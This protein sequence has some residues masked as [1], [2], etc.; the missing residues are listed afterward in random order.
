MKKKITNTKTKTYIFNDG[1]FLSTSKRE[2]IK[3][4]L[5]ISKLKREI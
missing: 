1:L 5:K 4:T 3:E 2:Y